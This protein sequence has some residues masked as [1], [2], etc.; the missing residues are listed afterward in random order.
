MPKLNIDGQD[1]EVPAGENLVLAARRIGVEVPVF[2]YHEKLSIAA[3]CRM[4]LVEIE[5][6]PKLQP[7]CQT[8]ATDNMIVKTSSPKVIEARAAVMEFLLVNHP[9]DC[10]ICDK[11]GECMLQ[12]NYMGHDGKS[13]RQQDTKTAKPRLEVLGPLVN[14]NAERCIMCTRC[15]RFMDEIPKNTQLGVF[16][17][18][19]RNVIGVFDGKPLDDPYSLNVVELCPVGALGSLDFRFESRVWSLDKTNS[20]CDGCSK[21][22][23]TE[24]HSKKEHVYRMI[25]RRNDSVNDT[26]M[27]DEGRLSYHA[28]EEQ[29]AEE[30]LTD[31]KRASDATALSAAL[32]VLAN[33]VKEKGNGWG[34]FIS[35]TLTNEGA[36]AWLSYVKANMAQ[37]KVYFSGR[38]D[39]V[40]DQLLRRADKNPNRAGIKAIAEALGIPVGTYTDGITAKPLR[41]VMLGTETPDDRISSIVNAAQASLVIGAHLTQAFKGAKV[42][43]LSGTVFESDG[44]FVNEDGRVQRVRPCH[45]VK[46]AGKSYADWAVML[47]QGLDKA[48]GAKTFAWANT[49]SVFADLANAVKGFSGMRLLGLGLHGKALGSG[50]A[51]ESPSH[52][53]ASSPVG[54]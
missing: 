43:L 26:W 8:V 27:C 40:G 29:R 30:P 41:V 36:F 45:G 6:M 14:Y 11:A 16:G 13:S 52:Q 7:A 37:A 21:G 28:H 44:S 38:A 2:C 51:T 4:C 42:A 46:F 50:R 34:V 24:T 20:V 10:P 18:G 3:N 15:V 53:Q 48:V 35:P 12:D 22:C 23:N 47:S 1:I 17:R 9:L 54:A 32:G 31:G 39:G 25:P 49:E 5:K 33:A 19:D